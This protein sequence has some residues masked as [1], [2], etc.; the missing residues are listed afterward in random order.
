MPFD[1]SGNFNRIHNWTNDA[2]AN[3][4][5]LASRHDAEDTNF[6]AGL[7][8]CLTRDGQ[9]Q[10]TADIPMNGRKITNLAAP[11]NPTDAATKGYADALRNF[12]TG[13]NL[14]G[15][16]PEARIGFTMADIGFGA[17]A[18]GTPAGSVSRWVWNDE[19]DLSGTDIAV[20]TDTGSMSLGVAMP[21]NM[22]QALI[23]GGRVHLQ[24]GWSLNTYVDSV[25]VAWKATKAGH[26]ANFDHNL[27]TGEM[28]LWRSN[29]SLAA[30]ATISAPQTMLGF[31]GNMAT[32]RG[33]HIQHLED[34]VA[35]YKKVHG[36]TGYYWRRTDDGTATG[37][38]LYD[39]MALND[40]GS[41]N[42]LASVVAGHYH[43]S[44]AGGFVGSTSTA[45]LAVNGAGPIVLRPNGVGSTTN[46]GT[47]DT[48]G[49][50]TAGGNLL[51]GGTTGNVLQLGPG[52]SGRV[53]SMAGGWYWDWDSATGNLWWKGASGHYATF[54]ADGNFRI[55]GAVATK[56]TGTVWA[57]PSDARIKTVVGDYEPGLAEIMQ[58]QPR[59]F[60]YKGNN[61]PEEPQGEPSSRQEPPFDQP[62]SPMP[63]NIN[64][65]T[66]PYFN[67]PHY[68][69][70]RNGT[71]VA[72]LVAQEVEAVMPEMVTRH[73]AY[74]DGEPVDDFRILD[75]NNL[76]ITLVNAVKELGQ[77]VEALEAAA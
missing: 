74:I 45:I 29:A 40:S 57:N 39:L 11:T 28:S 6:S 47:Y 27:A 53:L 68:D 60:T 66:V 46:Q 52:G 44:T 32:L 18:A 16:V 20:M 26:A 25:A 72:G 14:S 17:R 30:G 33:A 67:S 35:Y 64:E 5:I 1:G 21:A 58:L 61:T 31:S 43:Y 36:T 22:G 24:G 69:L 49:H 34:H 65:P 9:T 63:L 12:N 76:A 62:P 10:P 54:F 3:I 42:V 55:S 70:A 8:Q 59:R 73:A 7:S 51:A 23:L 2:A 75:I 19:P 15:A 48:S 41:L 13:I 71:E 38:N 4:K 37:A 77:R 50:F 56:T